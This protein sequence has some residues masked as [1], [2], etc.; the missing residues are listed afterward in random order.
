MRKVLLGCL[1][2]LSACEAEIKNDN[3]EVTEENGTQPGDTVNS[4]GDTATGDKGQSGE[5]P[6]SVF[7]VGYFEKDTGDY[8]KDVYVGESLSWN[9]ANKINISIDKIE[10]GKVEGHSVVA[11]NNRPFTG[12]VEN[13]SGVQTFKVR[14]PGSDKYDGSF[15]FTIRDSILEG[16]WRAYNKIDIPKRKY[17]LTKRQ[18]KY[19]PNVMLDPNKQYV[20]WEKPKNSNASEEEYYPYFASAT[21]QV[22]KI[23][24]SNKLLS[25]SD[26]A[27]LKNGDLVIIR[28][29]IYA[30]HG[31]SFKQR[32]LRVFFDAQKWYIPVYAD[33]RDDFT[34]IEKKN[35]QLLL[36]Y[37]KNAKEYY[38][39]FGR[40]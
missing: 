1:V 24:A 40:G 11:G 30:R 35:I 15:Q 3:A 14:E 18:F 16:T 27:N 25:V 7:Y 37:E 38:D 8:T 36:R 5:N 26:V 4:P 32:P 10:D 17:K 23:N 13:V 31:Y 21:D 20:N 34:E 39:Y 9:R 22:Y 19:D 6:S 2:V 33:I 29:T 28:N 12:T